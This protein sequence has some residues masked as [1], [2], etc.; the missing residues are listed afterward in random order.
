MSR[1]TWVEV[2]CDGCRCA[3][4]FLYP[5]TNKD[6]EKEGYLVEGSKHFCDQECKNTYETRNYISREL[7][8]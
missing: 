2:T 7:S 4:Q 8:R 6:I 5:F 3:E 1:R